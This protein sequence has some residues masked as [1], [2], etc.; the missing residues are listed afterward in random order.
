MFMPF[1]LCSA[2]VMFEQLME[3]VYVASFKSY[4]VY[5]DG[6]TGLATQSKNKCT[7]YTRYSF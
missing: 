5:L 6:V 2:P 4:L 7:I 3:A 1:G